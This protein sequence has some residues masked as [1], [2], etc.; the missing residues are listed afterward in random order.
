MRENS[1]AASQL[2]CSRGWS[3]NFSETRD[4]APSNE[5]HH[6]VNC[7][8]LRSL[9]ENVWLRRTSCLS[10]TPHYSLT[11]WYLSRYFGSLNSLISSR[12]AGREQAQAA[13]YGLNLQPAVCWNSIK[14]TANSQPIFSNHWAELT[15]FLRNLV[16]FDLMGV[17]VVSLNHDE[18]SR[19]SSFPKERVSGE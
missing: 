19:P 5:E 2:S 18:R 11:R 3:A 10:K 8:G 16:A 12:D 13:G 17:V 4:V 1:P 15:S 14:F 6:W 7:V 9:A